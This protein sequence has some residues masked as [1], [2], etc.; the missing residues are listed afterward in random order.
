MIIDMYNRY[1]EAS[2]TWK[3][4][5]ATA[6]V[7]LFV[8]L[9]QPV[10]FALMIIMECLAGPPMGVKTDREN[11]AAAGFDGENIII[12]QSDDMKFESPPKRTGTLK[13]INYEENGA[14]D[15]WEIADLEFDKMR[16]A[17]LK[18]CVD[19]MYQQKIAARIVFGQ[20]PECYRERVKTQGLRV[21]YAY[22][23]SLSA[24]AKRAKK[25]RPDSVYLALEKCGKKT[26]EEC[27]RDFAEGRS[28]KDYVVVGCR[29]DE[30]R[31][32]LLTNSPAPPDIEE[33]I[34]AMRAGK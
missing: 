16:K 6:V 4:I 19:T 28:Q 9:Y 24:V 20:T 25:G 32:C 3:G 13:V 2:P 12:Y 1:K 30:A 11:Y 31:T 34:K 14:D 23:V 15:R 18:D 17:G 26:D 7:A 22:Y 10:I 29:D 5:I 27:A 21:G 8:L 33:R